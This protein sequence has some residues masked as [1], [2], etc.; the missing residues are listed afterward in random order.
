MSDNSMRNIHRYEEFG[1]W[2]VR[3]RRRS[4]DKATVFTDRRYGGREASLRAALEFRN[5]QEQQRLLVEKIEFSNIVRKNNTSGIPGVRRFIGSKGTEYWQAFWNFSGK[6]RS[7]SFRV[8]VY[9]EAVA[10]NKAIQARR[11]AE[12]DYRRQVGHLITPWKDSAVAPR[13]PVG[14]EP[15]PPD[16]LHEHPPT[17]R[18][19]NKSGHV[20]VVWNDQSKAWVASWLKDGKRL[21]KSFSA[22]K[23]GYAEA[24]KLAVDA[25]KA[26]E[27][28]EPGNGAHEA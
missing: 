18:S 24:K 19:T 28:A 3:F 20:G 5:A 22:R 16:A 17:L 27:G 4:K 26:G 9:G 1:R 7:R 13:V 15:P 23:Y 6:N 10:K 8:T 14:A 21:A 12:E 25:R 11:D 2:Q